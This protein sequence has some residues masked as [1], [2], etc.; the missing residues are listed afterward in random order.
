ML[1]ELDPELT[2]LL[3]TRAYVVYIRSPNTKTKWARTCPAR[4]VPLPWCL[5]EALRA[6]ETQ[7]R[8][9]RAT[10]QRVA[11]PRAGVLHLHLHRGVSQPQGRMQRSVS[12]NIRFSISLEMS[13]RY[14]SYQ[15]LWET[16]ISHLLTY[17]FGRVCCNTTQ[18]WSSKS[19]RVGR[20]TG[21]GGGD[22]VRQGWHLHWHVF[23]LL[24]RQ[25]VSKR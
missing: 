10:L 15:I 22:S 16:H 20:Y 18:R 14:I 4:T 13:L 8:F 9:L 23:Q 7:L 3:Y 2:H 19:W 12:T 25:Q 21:G 17:N 5:G 11:L 1:T 6:A 24:E